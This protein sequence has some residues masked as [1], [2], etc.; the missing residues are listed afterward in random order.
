VFRKQKK[1]ATENPWNGERS[2]NP[3]NQYIKKLTCMLIR[4]ALR[5]EKMWLSNPPSGPAIT[6]K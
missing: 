1:R 5:I 2:S 4:K 6:T 3:T